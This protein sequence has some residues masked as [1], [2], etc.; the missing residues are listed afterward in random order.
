MPSKTW[1]FKAGFVSE[2]IIY[3]RTVD[4]IVRS[5]ENTFKIEELPEVRFDD[6]TFSK[7]VKFLHDNSG[8]KDKHRVANSVVAKVVNDKINI[9]FIGGDYRQNRAAL[10]VQSASFT[11]KKYKENE[12]IYLS[13]SYPTIF[14]QKMGN[15]GSQAPVLPLFKLDKIDAAFETA[16][17]SMKPKNIYFNRGK[18]ING[19]FTNK[20]P[21]DS[22]YANFKR[23]SNN[24]TNQKSIK[25][26]ATLYTTIQGFDSTIEVSVYPYRGASK[27][28]YKAKLTKQF[29]LTPEGKTNFQK[30]P[31][32]SKLE[33]MLV[34]IANE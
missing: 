29:F 27:I 11:I 33:P 3:D 8:N 12:Y 14:K 2:G 6:D 26:V 20:F 22:V 23:K 30:F 7:T 21:D 19:E 16:F 24:G 13:I 1:R 25:K 28:F 10:A 18:S 9:Q 31:Q 34:A 17:T 32:D 5:I 15:L 4:A